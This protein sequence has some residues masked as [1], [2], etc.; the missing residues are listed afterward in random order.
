MMRRAAYGAWKRRNGAALWSLDFAS[1]AFAR[2][3]DALYQTGAPTDGSSS[4]IA[5]AGTNVLVL[6]DLGD[7]AG[8]LAR[9]EKSATNYI[10]RNREIGSAP[11][12]TTG[13]AT[14]TN[15]LG[16]PT[17]SDA[18]RIEVASG[19]NER[20]QTTGVTGWAAASA[21]IRATSGTPGHWLGVWDGSF[22]VASV[23]LSTTYQ[24]VIAAASQSPG[25]LYPCSGQAAGS[26]SAGARDVRV[27]LVQ[28]E[29][30]RYATSPIVTAGASATRAAD[31]LTLGSGSV[32]AALLSTRGQFAQFS[33][34]WGTADLTSGDVRWLFTL[35]GTGNG[36]RI[37][38]DGTNVLLEAVESA[39]VKASKA[40]GTVARNALVGPIGWDPAAGLVYINGV[41]GSAGSAWTWGNDNLR[42]GGIYGFSSNELDGRLGA[43]GGW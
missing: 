34:E 39:T 26:T 25:Y 29:D 38:H 3:S 4:Y 27:S 32:P 28:H 21:Y 5:T 37:R 41:A 7:G 42:V 36:M 2:A 16:G 23:T 43:L 1:M 8:A 14:I 31:T 30:G 20:Y 17:G 18:E 15:N 33:P 12:G 13:A 24:R 9:F 11:W 40:F 22:K 19:N 35:G 10:Q 6:E